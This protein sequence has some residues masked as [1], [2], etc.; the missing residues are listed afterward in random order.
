MSLLNN[1]KFRVSKKTTFNLH[2]NLLL[3]MPRNWSFQFQ[4]DGTRI[5]YLMKTF[6]NELMLY[7][8]FLFIIILW[9]LVSINFQ[10]ADTSL[11]S[12][13]IVWIKASEQ[14]KYLNLIGAKKTISS[15]WKKKLFYK[16]VQTVV[17]LYFFMNIFN[18]FYYVGS[19]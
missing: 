4:D 9:F 8:I 16:K 3:D 11:L 10:F 19:N 2:Y 12:S 5:F 14:K 15:I 1:I 7:M 13:T 17:V 18:Y 6:H